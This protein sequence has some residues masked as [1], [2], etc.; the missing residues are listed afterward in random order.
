MN[1]AS[2]FPAE[3]IRHAVWLYFCFSLSLRNVEKLL[4]QRGI[5]VSYAIRYCTKKFGPLIALRLM[6]RRPAPS[7]RWHLDEMVCWI[8]GRRMYLWRR[9][10]A[11]AE[12]AWAAAVA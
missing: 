1:R 4:A 3:V 7:S 11:E 2:F 8:G 10:R 12:A 6:K 9:F 5:E